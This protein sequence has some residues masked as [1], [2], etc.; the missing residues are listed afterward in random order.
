M[1]KDKSQYWWIQESQIRNHSK[2]VAVVQDARKDVHIRFSCS[3]TEIPMLPY[4]VSIAPAELMPF[5]S[6]LN[7]HLQMQFIRCSRAMHSLECKENLTLR[8]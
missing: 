3:S 7:F 4:D 5:L 8:I 2:E 6:L 1:D